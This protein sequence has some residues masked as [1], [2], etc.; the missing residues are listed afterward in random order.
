MNIKIQIND[1][2]STPEFIVNGNAFLFQWNNC[3]KVTLIWIL[4]M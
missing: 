1:S 3:L 2:A 4:T